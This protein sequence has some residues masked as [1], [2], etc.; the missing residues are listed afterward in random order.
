M[1]SFQRILTMIVFFGSLLI[2]A[3]F[4]TG[5]LLDLTA[6]PSRPSATVPVVE[7]GYT[8][9]MEIETSHGLD[10]YWRQNEDDLAAFGWTASP[11]RD[12]AEVL[13]LMHV[14][15]NRSMKMEKSIRD[16]VYSLLP[17]TAVLAHELD[18]PADIKALAAEIVRDRN[19]DP[20]NGAQF[21]H[22]VNCV[23]PACARMRE[24]GVGS[25]RFGSVIVYQGMREQRE[26]SSRG[27]S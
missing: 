21:Y 5:F 7:I 17:P 12:R 1:K 16:I 10:E 4:T 6:P 20:T 25:S 19:P 13:A 11:S 24:H 9:P 27:M 15:M 26:V 18:V 8:E 23:S 2:V 22:A 3:L 14:A